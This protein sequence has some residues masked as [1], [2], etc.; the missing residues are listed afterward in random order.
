MLIG[1]G[2]DAALVS[3]A[4]ETLVSADM[5][6]EGVHFDL[7]FS[8]PSDAGFKAMAV[9]VSDIAAMGGRASFALVCLGAP[10]ETP[11]ATLDMLYEGMGE[12]ASQYSVTI[13]GGDL[14]SAPLLTIAITVMGE[15]S[16]RVIARSG[17][18]AGDA[19]CVT[20]ALGA[21]SAGLALLRL[22]PFD[23]SAEGIAEQFPELFRS[24]MRPEERGE[25]GPALAR[26]GVHAMIDLSDGLARDAGHIADASGLG[27]RIESSRIPIA[28]GVAETA[29]LLGA[30]AAAVA[31]GGGED[32]EL[33]F[34]CAPEDV[35]RIAA[36][37]APVPVTVV[38]SFTNDA[39]ER[40]LDLGS[41]AMQLGSFGWEHF[42]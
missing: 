10:P 40:T 9:N 32:Y 20:G 18:K 29:E 27:L 12:A 2:D 36:A 30:G 14:S 1:P 15:P 26:H 31:I 41:D 16:A 38:G 3:T 33:C 37:L 6:V 28:M 23:V 42:S 39:T 4:P 5:L 21:S 17:A 35:A 25:V 24:H 22:M 19:L 34:A 8:S 13:V 11:V 7:A